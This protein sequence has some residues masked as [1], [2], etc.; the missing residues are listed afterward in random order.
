MKISVKITLDSA[1]FT[2]QPLK[3]GKTAEKPRLPPPK[4]KPELQTD[5]QDLPIRLVFFHFMYAVGY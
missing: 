3:S 5:S 4:S 2:Y 1:I